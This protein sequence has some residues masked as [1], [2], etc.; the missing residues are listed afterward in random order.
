MKKYIKGMSV[1][2]QR[3]LVLDFL[4]DFS[5][6]STLIKKK[7]IGWWKSMPYYLENPKLRNYSTFFTVL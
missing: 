1:I 5:N 7:S 6:L 3:E 4:I 2:G